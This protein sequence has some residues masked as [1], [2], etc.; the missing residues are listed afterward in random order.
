MLVPCFELGDF[1]TTRTDC[2][3]SC[4]LRSGPALAETCVV[5]LRISRSAEDEEGVPV[6][7]GSGAP[8]FLLAIK[9]VTLCITV[10]ETY[11]EWS[12]EYEHVPANDVQPKLMSK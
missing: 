12:A 10:D 3:E 9:Q 2:E 11:A 4:G 8:L 7:P 1:K 6:R 5:L